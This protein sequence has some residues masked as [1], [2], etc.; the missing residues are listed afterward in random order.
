MTHALATRSDSAFVAPRHPTTPFD[1]SSGRRSFVLRHA[2]LPALAFLA[3]LAGIGLG[4]VD[5]L[6]GDWIYAL[7]GHAWAWRDAFF[8]EDVV[9]V[10]GRNLSLTL[11]LAVLVTWL[12]ALRQPG[13]RS[14]RRPLGYLLIATSASTLLVSFIKAWSNMD[15]PWDLVRYGGERPYV[16][17]LS[18]RPVGLERGRCFPAGHASGG[19]AWLALYF[20]FGIVRP[21]WRWL[22]IALGAGLGLLFGLSQQL[23]G[24]H[25]LSH[26][27]ST[28]AICWFTALGIYVAMW[29]R[30]P[31]ESAPAGSVTA[32]TDG[33]P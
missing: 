23:R 31:P 6:L 2:V 15:C 18:L 17:L 25:F 7:G 19:Y 27:V 14:L 5:L 22:G 9:H 3:M 8:T 12:L 33:G 4:H 1:P 28:A 20:F 30:P 11:W 32:A 21:R 26:D 13:L 24:A 16:G 29:K 10:L